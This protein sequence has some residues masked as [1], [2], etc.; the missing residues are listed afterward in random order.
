MQEWTFFLEKF[1]IPHPHWIYQHC[2]S[3]RKV[4]LRRHIPWLWLDALALA[5]PAQP[6]VPLWFTVYALLFCEAIPNGTDSQS[7]LFCNKQE[8]KSY[9]MVELYSTIN[10]LKEVTPLSWYKS[11]PSISLLDDTISTEFGTENFRLVCDF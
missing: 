10:C 8:I 1:N 11:K 5:T 7:T 3:S 9:Y 2:I 4:L 6:L